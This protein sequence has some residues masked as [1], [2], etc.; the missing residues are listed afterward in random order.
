MRPTFK[1]D[2]K[3]FLIVLRRQQRRVGNQFLRT[4]LGWR[5]ERYARVREHLIESGAVMRG[6]GRGGSVEISA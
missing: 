2:T 6:R 1:Q 5:D 3:K 4:E